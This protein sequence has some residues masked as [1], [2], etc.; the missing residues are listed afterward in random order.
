MRMKSFRPLYLMVLPVVLLILLSFRQPGET[1]PKVLV[2][3]KTE[4]FRHASIDAGKT[5]FKKMAEEKGFDVDFTEDGKSIR[6][7]TIL[8]KYNAVCLA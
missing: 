7:P 3:S 8:K 2:F 5:A 1:R 4:G 6:T